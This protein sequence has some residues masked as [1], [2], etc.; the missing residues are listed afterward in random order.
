MYIK[1]SYAYELN[2]DFK[3]HAD[4]SH[5]SSDIVSFRLA[6]KLYKTKISGDLRPNNKYK[7]RENLQNFKTRLSF[8]IV[9]SH[10]MITRCRTSFESRERRSFDSATGCAG[11][12]ALVFVEY[13]VTYRIHYRTG[14]RSMHAKVEKQ[15][16]LEPATLGE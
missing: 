12:C 5:I 16:Q 10:I 6:N 11:P 1:F 9:P 4:F 13:K 3:R 14:I 8:F 2:I 15:A 7:I